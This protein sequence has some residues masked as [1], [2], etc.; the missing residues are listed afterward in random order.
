M[1]SVNICFVI[2][3][4]DSSEI[5]ERGVSPQDDLAE[6]ELRQGGRPDFPRLVRLGGGFGSSGPEKL[7]PG[8]E[9]DH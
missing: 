6:D 8:I 9:V 1:L 7:E 2:F 4:L 5:F 3:Y